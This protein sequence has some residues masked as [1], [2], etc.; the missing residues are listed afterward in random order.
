[1][2]GRGAGSESAERSEALSGVFPVFQTPFRDD[3]SIDRDVLEHEIRWMYGHG[4]NGIVMAMVSETLRLSG[5]ERRALAEAACETGLAHGSVIISVGAESTKVA[6]D[7]AR[8]AESVGASA[9][10]AIPPTT[11]ASLEDELAD[12]YRGLLDATEVPVVIQDASGYVGQ[13]MSISVQAELL[14]EYPQRVLF[15]PEAEPIGP[16]LTELREATDGA[17][18]VFEGSG[19]IALVDSY[20]RGIVGTM[21]GA[22][23]CWALV[24]L[25]DALGR[26]DQRRIDAINGPLTALVSMQTG[27]DGFIA[28]E[29]HLL[30]RQ[31]VFKSD[32]VRRP[33]G[34]RLDPE[35]RY[36]VDHR[37]DL[38]RDAVDDLLS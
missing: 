4:V 9:L 32:R 25:W 22:E 3:D 34:Y 23:V 33:V 30:V 5:E 14:D 20:K 17:A 31:G 15:K 19:G 10:M 26:G 24:A 21:P 16:R 37:F 12:Y 38:L 27:L 7:Y 13:A 35:S 1:M 8:H 11:V 18:R 36:E 6:V 28:V 2:S 29:K